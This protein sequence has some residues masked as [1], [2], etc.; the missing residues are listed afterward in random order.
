MAT[1][2]EVLGT[3][4]ILGGGFQFKFN[5]SHFLLFGN[6]TSLRFVGLAATPLKL[7]INF[8][9]IPLLT[10]VALIP[11]NWLISGG[12]VITVS[13]VNIVGQ[14]IE[15]TVSGSFDTSTYT[16]TVPDGLISD[17]GIPSDP[18]SYFGPFSIQFAL[19]SPAAGG[20]AFNGGFN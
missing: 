10:G 2:F 18:F 5:R 7:T 3:V 15:L 9:R 1:N 8:D 11:G 19:M 6:P 13:A 14:T 17:S 4:G 20:S 16:L 12:S